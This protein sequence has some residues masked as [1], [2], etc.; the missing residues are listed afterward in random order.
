M[1]KWD[2]FFYVYITFLINLSIF[3]G[4]SLMIIEFICC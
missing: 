1:L 3:V 2:S 4:F